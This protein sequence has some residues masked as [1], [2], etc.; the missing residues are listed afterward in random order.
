VDRPLQLKT[1]A[2]SGLRFPGEFRSSGVPGSSGFGK[3]GDENRGTDYLLNSVAC[4]AIPV[5][6]TEVFFVRPVWVRHSARPVGARVSGGA[7]I[8]GRFRFWILDFGFRIGLRERPDKGQT[9]RLCLDD[10]VK[11][12][13]LKQLGLKRDDVFVCQDTALD[14][15]KA[16]NLALQF[17]LKTV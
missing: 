1:P 17:R 13:G 12:S 5:T 8:Q 16:A 11:L 9:F 7:G 2:P 4:S 6:C 15:E 14:D 10:K 3:Q